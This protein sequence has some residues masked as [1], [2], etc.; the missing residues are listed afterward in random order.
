[1]RC[2]TLALALV[3]LVPVASAAPKAKPLESYQRGANAVRARV[4]DIN[5]EAVHQ[6]RADA[7]SKLVA[8]LAKDG[9]IR[10]HEIADGRIATGSD[11]RERALD[12]VRKQGLAAS[13]ARLT[14]DGLTRSGKG[15]I[16]VDIDTRQKLRVAIAGHEQ[17]GKVSPLRP[18]PRKKVAPEKAAPV[19][20]PSEDAIRARAQ[21]ISEGPNSGTMD[22]NWFRARD[23]LIREAQPQ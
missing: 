1:V 14:I 23:E 11:L 12:A 8:S 19:F 22:Q 4:K 3:G 10:T 6:I 13:D 16:V 9:S 15:I 18:G 17:L 5:F 21:K 2:I 7:T 20:E